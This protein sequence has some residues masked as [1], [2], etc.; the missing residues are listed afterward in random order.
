MFSRVST[1]ASEPESFIGKAFRFAATLLAF[2]AQLALAISIFLDQLLRALARYPVALVRTWLPRRPHPLPQPLHDAYFENVV[3]NQYAQPLEVHHPTSLPELIEHVRSAERAGKRV[4]PIGAGH[5]FSDVAIADGVLLALRSLC[6]IAPAELETLLDEATL[7]ARD[8]RRDML[9]YAEAGVAIRELNQW[10]YEHEQALVNMGGYDGQTLSGALSTGTHGSGRELG[11]MCD[12][13]RSVDVVTEGGRALRIEPTRGISSPERHAARY[14]ELELVQDDDTFH[15]VVV[16][17]G[18]MGVIHSYVIEVV[19]CYSLAEHRE[20]LTWRQ[21]RQKLLANDYQPERGKGKHAHIRHFEFLISPYGRDGNNKCLVTYRWLAK[22]D[23]KRQAGRTR[24]FLPTLVTSV[25]EFDQIYA[26]ALSVWPSLARRVVDL[27][28]TQLV[29]SLYV[30]QSYQVLHLGDANYV[31]AYSSELSFS[32]EPDADT[33]QY[34]RAIDRLLELAE[35]QAARHRYHSV[36][37]SVR[38]VQ[39]SPHLLALSQGRDSAIIEIP[40]LASVAGGW[41]LLRYY[42]RCLFNEFKARAH[43][44]QANFIIG[45]DRISESYSGSFD[46][47]LATRA[48]LCPR[49]TF[50]NSF[51]ERMGLRTLTHARYGR[52]PAGGS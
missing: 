29:D 9:V 13:V 30:A 36:P 43:W 39:K 41:D 1:P 8:V 20:A 22:R 28:V 34:I 46:T 4:H 23:A 40:M 26:L 16:A 19:P 2:L 10:L 50:D 35:Q 45:A 31:P 18:S 25:R 32:A 44:G 14:P 27:E 42:E 7:A 3:G 37:L 38:F 33:P 24:P 11:P 5:S 17:L 21:V 15:S 48:R 47:W 12:M 52:A 49:G 6:A 51:T